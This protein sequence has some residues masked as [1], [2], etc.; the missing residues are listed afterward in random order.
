MHLSRKVH[1]LTDGNR[2][3]GKVGPS[4]G[5]FAGLSKLSFSVPAFQVSEDILWVLGLLSVPL[6]CP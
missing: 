1:G 4:C 2:N 5:T 6:H 3:H